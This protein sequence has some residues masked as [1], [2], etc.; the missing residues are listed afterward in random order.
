[1]PEA[2]TGEPGVTPSPARGAL[3]RA[4][5]ILLTDK[6]GRILLVR[7]TDG[8]G[9]AFP[10]GGIEEGESP[11][12]CAR[13]EFVEETGSAY[14]GEL[15]LWTRRIKDGVDFT[16]YMGAAEAFLPTLN[17]EHD[18]FTWAS[19]EAAFTLPLHP[20]ARVALER[21]A[22]HELDIAKAMAAGDLVSPQRYHNMLLV[23]I[24][25]TGTGIAYRPSLEEFVWRDTEIY[26]TPEFLQRCNGLPVILEHPKKNVLDSKEFKS[27]IV[28]T[29]FLP[30]IS[31]DSVWSIAKIYD[32]KVADML[33]TEKM[34]TSPGVVIRTI[35]SA[36]L[37][38]SDGKVLL[39]EGEPSLV[40]HIALLYSG[41]D[42]ELESDAAAVK[43]GLGVW[44]RGQ[45]M[46]GVDSVD[47]THVAD[48]ELLDVVAR[49]AKLH[50][51]DRLIRN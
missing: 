21:F 46:S 44:D 32:A 35:D 20:G 31:G 9:W 29:V 49:K 28:G 3:L 13:R 2:V 17:A 48:W 38:M 11:E 30:Y 45:G 19:R 8:Q 27:R 6:E 14:E 7:R 33:E 37:A 40:D 34:S 43:R 22:M 39:L 50:D 10:G 18:L 23:A 41:P 47:A 12:D 24:R 42:P 1:M 25:I 51:I 16:T 26:L 36:E 15:K 5:G 4:A